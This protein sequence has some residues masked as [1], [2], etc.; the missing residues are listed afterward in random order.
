[1]TNI[2][3]VPV[4][5]TGLSGLPGV[6]VFYA[7]DA[8]DAGAGLDAFFSAIATRFPNGLSWSLAT[9]GDK[10]SMETGELTGVWTGGTPINRSGAGGSSGYAA[11][12]GCAAVWLTNGITNGRRRRGRTFLAPLLASCY[13]SDGTIESAT[14]GAI[15][16]AAANLVTAGSISVWHRPSPGGSDGSASAVIGSSIPDRVTALRSRR[17]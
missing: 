7:G 14:F 17:Y 5:W 12:V 16:T 8:V 6:S 1:M 15:Q 9:S 11:G 2:R 3:R 4:V 13:Q 10:I